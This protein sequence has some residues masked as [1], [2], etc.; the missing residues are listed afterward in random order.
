MAKSS[1]YRGV[2]LFRP[3]GKWRA[4]VKLLRAFMTVLLA[5]VVVELAFSYNLDFFRLHLCFSC[6]T[7]AV[8]T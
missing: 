8:D 1:P 4:Q 2:T 6:F 7:F 5:A 3:T